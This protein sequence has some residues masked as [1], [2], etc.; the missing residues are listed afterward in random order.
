MKK[1]LLLLVLLPSLLISC[2]SEEIMEASQTLTEPNSTAESPMPGNA[3]NPYDA[4][5]R[6]HNNILD[7]YEAMNTVNDTTITMISN[8]VKEIALANTDVMLLNTGYSTTVLSPEEIGEIVIDPAANLNTVI[9]AST[10][11]AG[12]KTSLSHFI[13]SLLLLEKEKYEV[14]YQFIIS[15]ETTVIDNGQ[16]NNFDKRALLLTTSLLRHWYFHI[17]ERRDPDWGKSKGNAVGALKGA[18]K[19]P[20]TAVTG[21][22][23]VGIAQSKNVSPK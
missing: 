11:T 10:L 1:I 9:T 17:R 19:G 21:S 13:D 6:A 3:A 12:A 2:S 16:F 5:G 15:Y 4:A 20:F 8:R 14:I 22:L 23:V 18:L 7:L